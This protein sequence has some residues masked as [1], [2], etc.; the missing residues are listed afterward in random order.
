MSIDWEAG[1]SLAQFLE[2]RKSGQLKKPERPKSCLLCGER[3][4]YWV[5]GNY[6]RHLEEGAIAE[7]IRIP[8]WK[9]KWCGGTASIAPQF[10]VRRRR[11]TVKVIAAGVEG[12]GSKPASYRGEVAKLGEAGPSP[13]QLFQWVKLV[14]DRAGG[15]LFD[16]QSMCISAGGEP[17]ALLDAESV[18]CPNSGKAITPG[19]PER[20]NTLAKVLSFARVLFQEGKEFVLERLGLRFLREVQWQIFA[21]QVLRMQ[22]PQSKKPGILKIF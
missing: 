1:E 5:H 13:A 12:Y 18:A 10:A 11:Y 17:E 9:C 4:C 16:V 22:T 21:S 2:L 15:L 20:L 19:K 14:A 8:R 7:E 6:R 3:D